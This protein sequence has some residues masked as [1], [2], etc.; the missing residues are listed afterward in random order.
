M[1][2]AGSVPA[3]CG[4]NLLRRECAPNNCSTLQHAGKAAMLPRV[5]TAAPPCRWRPCARRGAPPSRAPADHTQCSETM[6]LK[7]HTYTSSPRPP[8]F[9]DQAV[10]R[11]AWLRSG[12]RVAAHH[13]APLTAPVARVSTTNSF[14]TCGKSEEGL[15]TDPKCFEPVNQLGAV[16]HGMRCSAPALSH[17]HP[18]PRVTAKQRQ[19]RRP[20]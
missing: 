6:S 19:A 9:A 10:A 1:W 12:S 15:M 18:R 13:A 20:F 14:S 2:E 17:R 16:R 5:P 7:V 11:N 3:S 8:G 4:A